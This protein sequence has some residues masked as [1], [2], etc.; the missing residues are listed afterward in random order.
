MA[1]YKLVTD[2]LLKC[3]K[4]AVKKLQCMVG[5]PNGIAT[6][7][8][9]GNVPANQL[10]NAGGGGYTSIQYMWTVGGTANFS[11]PT[12]PINGATTFIS[13]T[14]VGHNVRVFFNGSYILGTNTGA[15]LHYTKTLGSNTITFS[16]AITTGDQISIETI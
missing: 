4:D 16:S 1:I 9:T 13:S 14:L 2:H 7:D 3:L 11:T 8:S 15:I 6:L 12:P 5:S 10:A